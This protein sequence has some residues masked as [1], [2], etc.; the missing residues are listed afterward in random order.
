MNGLLASRRVKV[1]ALA[2]ATAPLAASAAPPEGERL[3]ASE[4]APCHGPAGE[5]GRGPTL[6]VPRLTRVADRD[7]LIKLIDKGIDGTEMPGARIDPQQIAQVATWVLRLGR[8]PPPHV[9]GDPASG[10]RLY[11]GK[12]GCNLCHAIDGVGG[13]LG[14]DLSDAGLRRGV[15]Y[16]RTALVDPEADVPRSANAY[17]SDV[18]LSQNFLAVRAVTRDGR[19]TNGVRVNEDT[20]SIQLLDVAGDI[21]SFLKSELAELHKDWGRSPMP[22]YRDALSERE[23]DDLVAFLVTLRGG[24]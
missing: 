2:V 9:P 5:G 17:R 6:A 21:H 18:S 7:S 12:G 14:T 16:L 13:A 11:W 4:C 8:R 22:T 3:F 15:A 24:R 23:L 1:L 10:K 20:F 19:E